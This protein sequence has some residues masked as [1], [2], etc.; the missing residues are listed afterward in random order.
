MSD[1]TT[2]GRQQMFLVATG[3]IAAP[4]L[5]VALY[6]T[7]A[8]PGGTHTELTLAGYHRVAVDLTQGV[9]IDQVTNVADSIFG[10]LA[11]GSYLGVAIHDDN[12]AD[13]AWYWHDEGAPIT[14][15]G[16]SSVTFPAGQMIV[17]RTT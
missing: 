11:A 9:S 1:W 7:S 6:S 16:S 12:S 3:A 5:Y 4:Q 17:A 10:P 14:I 13:Q 15:P 2:Y 8:D